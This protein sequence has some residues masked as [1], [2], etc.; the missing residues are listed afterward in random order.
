MPSFD[1]PKSSGGYDFDA[2]AAASSG[3]DVEPQEV[4]DER[5]RA[6]ASEFRSADD[7]AK[8]CSFHLFVCLRQNECSYSFIPLSFYAGGRK[9]SKISSRNCQ[10]EKEDSKGIER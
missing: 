7:E 3:E 5:A 4:R 9:K 6:A 1:T 10:C 8:V 2:P